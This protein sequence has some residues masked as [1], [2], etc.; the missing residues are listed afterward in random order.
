MSSVH[1]STGTLT[2]LTEVSVVFF[3][4]RRKPLDRLLPSLSFH[5]VQSFDAVLSALRAALFR[6]IQIW[7]PSPED[8]PRRG[9]VTVPRLGPD[10]ATDYHFIGCPSR[11]SDE[12]VSRQGG[13]SA[14]EGSSSKFLHIIRSVVAG[15]PCDAVL[16]KTCTGWGL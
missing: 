3:S 13:P 10:A 8:A 16:Q 6:K 15:P 4:H 7:R 12:R 11:D 1:I 2:A 5:I 9:A 14:S